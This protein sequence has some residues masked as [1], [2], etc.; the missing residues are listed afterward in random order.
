METDEWGKDPQVRFLRRVFS[1]MEEAQ[2]GLLDKIG[3]SLFDERLKRI[4]DGA[5]TIF[6][7]AWAMAL[8]KGM[9]LEEKDLV[10]LYI[11]SLA[12]V[13]E[14]YKISVP[15]DILPSDEDIKKIVFEVTR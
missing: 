8:R 13:L 3:I 1:H 10:H 6:E 4:R 5:L 2:K 15:Q 7:R 14:R 9:N 12:Y 11:F